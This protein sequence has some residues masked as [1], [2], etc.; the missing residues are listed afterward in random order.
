MFEAVEKE[1]EVRQAVDGMMPA[2]CMYDR[3]LGWLG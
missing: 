1:F 3:Q 2:P